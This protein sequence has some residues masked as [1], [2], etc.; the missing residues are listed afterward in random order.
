M[1]SASLH[2][3]WSEVRRRVRHLTDLGGGAG[4]SVRIGSGSMLPFKIT[5]TLCALLVRGPHSDLSGSGA[6]LGFIAL[7]ATAI[8]V[9]AKSLLGGNH[10]AKA[11]SSSLS[12]GDATAVVNKCVPEPKL[13]AVVEEGVHGWSGESHDAAD[14]EFEAMIATTIPI[15]AQ[16]KAFYVKVRGTSHRNSDRTSRTRIIGECSTFDSI[17]LVPEP[18][19][20]YGDGT[21]IAVRRRETNKQL[22]YLE[23][24]LAGEITRDENKHGPHWIAF[25][26]RKTHHPDTG[27]T[28]GAVIRVI[29]L[30]D[31]FIAQS[32]AVRAIQVT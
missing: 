7:A 22:G 19:N 24:R 10:E 20:H 16:E 4:H 21:A 2:A 15:E 32:D 17:L 1:S 6:I 23:S 18:E 14:A 26:R 29:R 27:K 13:S 9:F 5:S 11:E 8:V 3:R 28:V 25:F 12:R 30:S 31:E